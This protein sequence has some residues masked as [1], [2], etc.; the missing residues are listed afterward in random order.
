MSRKI[1]QPSRSP[2]LMA[3]KTSAIDF[4]TNRDR[5]KHE[6]A[7]KRKVNQHHSPPKTVAQ[8][9]ASV[10]SDS[11]TSDSLTGEDADGTSS[12]NA[13]AD[14][15]GGNDGDTDVQAP[16][17]KQFDPGEGQAGHT[18]DSKKA[19]PGNEEESYSND[20]S[21]SSPRDDSLGVPRKTR[22]PSPLL[23]NDINSDDD[24]D[25][26]GVDLISESGDE[27]L[28]V[29]HQEEKAIID[30][31]EGNIGLPLPLSP[32]NSPSFSISSADFVNPDLELSP[33][34]TDDPFFAEQI[35]LLNP[36]SF[37]NETDYYG[38]NHGQDLVMPFE[39]V[40]RRRVRFA[41]PLMLP[42]E[43]EE[44]ASLQP[45]DATAPLSESSSIK[46]TKDDSQPAEMA[47]D[48]I[49]S[50]P[51]GH[52]TSDCSGTGPGYQTP[53]EGFDS[54]D[55]DD[56]ASSAG[57]SSGYETDEG[58]TT[59]EEDVPAF[60]TTRPSALLR[61]ASSNLSDRLASRS[62]PKTSSTKSP[63]QRRRGPTL[64]SWVA[65]PTK[66]MAL[67]ASSGKELIVYPAQRPAS[68]GGKVF[69]TISSNGHTSAQPS[70]RVLAPQLAAP[71]GLTATEESDVERSE[72]SSQGGAATPM[73]ST[74][75]NLMMSGLGV[76]GGNLLSGHA[77]GPPEAFFPFHS[78][79]TDGRVVLD[80]L[81]VDEDDDDDDDGESL[82][83]IEDFIDFGEDS[84]DSDH[85]DGSSTE[86][87]KVAKSDQTDAEVTPTVSQSAR[88]ASRSLF[89]HLDKGKVT[90]FRRNQYDPNTGL[91][92]ASSS[93]SSSQVPSP[94]KSNGFVAASAFSPLK[95]RKL[96]SDFDPSLPNNAAFAKRRMV[97]P[98]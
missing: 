85:D 26:T 89:D 37:A 83:N 71:P 33:W 43:T 93:S 82:L 39:D 74:S 57:N 87:P 59:D 81:D 36:H 78:I 41:E 77:L 90:A 13:E 68:K 14:N 1:P 31:E 79:G 63:F 23:K 47:S 17:E 98:H 52:A 44:T 32:P 94:I 50:N 97:S 96:S 67:I 2:L 80:S 45:D 11:S 55:N 4:A 40:P 64:G 16:S 19:M 86:S 54:A 10:D 69:P 48:A 34:L 65:D 8:P 25:Y 73:L 75:S 29:E 42:S 53:F 28:A 6:S 88:S 51:D 22:A 66:P 61:H 5:K 91:Y 92:R 21:K 76:R 9:G 62:L 15:E 30:S 70:P 56:V 12:E 72:L 49:E 7:P 27:G 24:D 60:A 95:K 35:N 84:E 20:I 18:H 38:H 46:S 3:G 58:E